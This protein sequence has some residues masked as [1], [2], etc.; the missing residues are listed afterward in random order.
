MNAR[1]RPAMVS[2]AVSIAL[3]AACSSATPSG[4]PGVDR[5]GQTVLRYQG[6]EVQAAISYRFASQN[7]GEEW[8]IVD[9]AVT[10]ATGE[11]VKIER[12]RVFVK[13]PDGQA[14][15]LPSQEEFTAAYGSL[16]STA[17]RAAVAADPLDYFTPREACELGFLAEPGTA[18]VFPET[19][20]NDRRVCS[21]RLFFR[22]PG[23][24]QAGTYTLGIDLTESKVRIPFKL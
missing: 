4:T 20:V 3:L 11:S 2:V 10:G 17:V 12:S 9:L 16:R 7:L 21:G 14:V 8:L 24:V 22:I 15:Y 13:P 19:W 18:L 1:T 6:P 23:G 5:M